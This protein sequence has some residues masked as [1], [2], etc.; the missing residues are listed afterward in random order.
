[1]DGCSMVAGGSSICSEQASEEYT[2]MSIDTI[3]NGK[4][5]LPRHATPRPAPHTPAASPTGLLTSF[6]RR[7]FFPDSSRS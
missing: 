1:M 7:A 2:L 6:H 4:V 5:G 3:I